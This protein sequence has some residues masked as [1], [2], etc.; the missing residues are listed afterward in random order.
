MPQACGHVTAEEFRELAFAL[1]EAGYR[2]HATDRGLQ[3]RRAGR[4][5]LLA[6]IHPSTQGQDD[7]RPAEPTPATPLLSDSLVEEIYW[8]DFYAHTSYTSGSAFFTLVA[9]R[10]DLPATVLDIGFGDGRDS[11]A[12]AR[13]GRRVIGIDRSHVGITHAAD[14]AARLGFDSLLRFVQCD[15]GEP[16]PLR[17]VIDG[18]RA[19]ASGAPMLFYARFLLHSVTDEVQHTLLAT[20]GA[21]AGPGNCLAAEFRTDAD[22]ATPK[23]HG[24][25][26]RRYQ[27][28][29]Q[30][31]RRLADEYGFA[32]TILQ[33]EG[34]GLSP[35]QGEDPYLYRIVAR[36]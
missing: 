21:A 29:A 14:A 4:D 20:I 24:G 17:A 31:G 1:I 23:V 32:T 9:A 15:V 27:D 5:E 3:L 35:Y 18:A 11:F 30:F 2:V 16:A 19:D 25:H 33:D 36:R 13:S 26:F 10:D 7:A 8:A 28:G 22:A 12:F 34:T 6:E